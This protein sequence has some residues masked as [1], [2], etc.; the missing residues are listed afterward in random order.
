[1][2]NFFLPLKATFANL[3]KQGKLV[4]VAPFR[5]LGVKNDSFTVDILI[6]D[7]CVLKL[8]TQI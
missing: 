3:E 4:N 7:T 1:M 2:T 8:N 5:G 6:L